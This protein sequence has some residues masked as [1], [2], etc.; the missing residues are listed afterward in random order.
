MIKEHIVELVM[1]H[2]LEDKVLPAN[3]ERMLRHRIESFLEQE[4]RINELVPLNEEID[5]KGLAQYIKTDLFDDVQKYLRANWRERENAKGTIV[6]KAVAYAQANS[7]MSRSRAVTLTEKV[8]AMLYH[9]YKSKLIMD[10]EIVKAEIQDHVENTVKRY[11]EKQIEEASKN[12]T[13][14]ISKI[15][16]LKSVVESNGL[17]SIDRSVQLMQMGRIDQV[18]M[19]LQNYLTSI[20]GMHR[21]SPD[22]GYGFNGKFY[23]KPLTVDALE[24]YPPKIVCTG[25]A[26]IDGK[27]ISSLDYNT[28]NYA[29]RHQLPIY[30]N[31]I[32][33]KKF[34]GGFDDPV[35]HE[36]TD[37]EGKTLTIPPKPFPP[38]I[39]CSISLDD[40]VMFDYVLLRTEEVLDDGT[41]ILSNYGQQN[42][43]Y[44]IKITANLATKNTAYSI[45]INGAS[46]SETLHY[47][48]FLKQASLGAVI[49]VKVLS[50]GDTL[51]Q[52]KTGNLD[53]VTGFE[54]IDNEIA[55]MEKIVEIE[56]YFNDSIH[57]PE[58][59]TQDYYYAV[60]Y[61]SALIRGEERTGG[62]SK[63]EFDMPLTA[64]LKQKIAES[65]DRQFTLSYI[66]S[67]TVTLFEKEY[68]L[69]AIRVFDSVKYQDIDKL[70]RKADA[71]DEN[72]TIKI[73]FLPS[74]G[75]SGTMRDRLFTEDVT[76]IQEEPNVSEENQER[77][78]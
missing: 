56:T 2:V 14:I 53:Y 46:N 61:L 28:I 62:W 23:S 9:Y 45:S 47:L 40:T 22:Y 1:D 44:R 11:T 12:T 69:S 6:S 34:L 32:T 29:N 16:E 57:I 7:S 31:V 39:P 33:A 70:K 52:G 4:E 68:E 35:Q 71:L 75:E 65:D 20:N 5:F 30:L 48:S 18:E 43:P 76:E 17:L 54:S 74:D 50:V 38:A 24:K 3:E 10:L 49:K 63:F 21:L 26:Q 42:L 37:L 19:A 77:T 25:T 73:T 60:S 51:A 15:D 72:D 27:Y 58:E 78:L 13:E 55:F 67:I 36:A 59:I 8:M 66:G 64:E 41:I